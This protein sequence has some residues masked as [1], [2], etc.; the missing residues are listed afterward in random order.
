MERVFSE[1][2]Y[3]IGGVTI[4]GVRFD[5]TLKIHKGKRNSAVIKEA[6]KTLSGVLTTEFKH[7]GHYFRHNKED[8]ETD[9]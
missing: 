1:E 8:C 4:D 2:E 6:D 3:I 7:Y 5:L 9:H